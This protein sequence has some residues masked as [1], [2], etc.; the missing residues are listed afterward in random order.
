MQRTDS[1]RRRRRKPAKRYK[2]NYPRLIISLMVT[3]LII[4]GSFKIVSGAVGFVVRTVK[5]TGNK[6]EINVENKDT[7]IE[8]NNE[9]QDDI[10]KPE[11]SEKKATPEKKENSSEKTKGNTENTKNITVAATGDVL[12]HFGMIN[13]GYNAATEA[14]D[15]TDHYE[16]VK[17]LISGV[18]LALANFEGTMAQDILP[19][20]A[21]PLFNAPD[22]VAT[23]LSY[24]G[25]DALCTANNHC[26]DSGVEGIES[27]INAINFN[28][29][30]HFGTKKQPGDNLLVIEKNGIKIGL[31]AYS[32][33][34]N[35][36]DENLA[37]ENSY[38]ISKMDFNT[39]ESDI[40]NAKQN[41]CDLVIVYAHW[42]NE[43]VFEQTQTQTDVAH[44]MVEWGAD[45]VLGS[46]PHVLQKTEIVKHEGLDKFIIYSLGNAISNQRRETIENKYTETGV[47]LK[48][49]IEKNEE[50]TLIK[51]VE[52]YPTWVNS[53]L[54]V[55]GNRKFELL[56]TQD[57][58][59]GGKYRD[60]VNEDTL[61]RILD[62]R[63]YA[64]KILNGESYPQSGN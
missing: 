55:N 29:M 3:I 58:I 5:G 62:A 32:E 22:A 19:L 40:K 57:F 10:K 15:F 63:D 18:D 14:Y 11:E 34:F 54:D 53:F 4:W 21:Y 50:N 28:N 46:H 8:I 31:L 60:S 64:L 52:M 9:K 47:I 49:S 39:M 42:G 38:M 59:E 30:K 44:L 2:I 43:Y 12:Y 48:F 35:G 56:N 36:L 61:E 24:A 26:L 17:D 20:A 37:E 16:K 41:G 6:T 1:N 33:L 27:T 13:A 51:S 45:L 25:F 23:A 7:N